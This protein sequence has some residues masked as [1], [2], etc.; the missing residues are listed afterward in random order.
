[1][2][3]APL[4]HRSRPLWWCGLAALLIAS[5][6]GVLVLGEPTDLPAL[7]AALNATATVLLIVGLRSIRGGKRELHRFVMLNAT[8]VSAAFLGSYL[9]YHLRVQSEVGPTPFRRE[10]AVKTAY[11]VMLASHVI[12]AMVNLPMVLR[13]L[14][15]AHRED[16]V[17]H[18]RLARW[19]WPIWFY[20]SLTGVL[21]YLAL[22][23]WN[24]PAPPDAP[25]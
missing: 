11:Y 25:R 15:L 23:H 18:R 8:L 3:Q 17:R 10:G 16:W 12:L 7:N 19:T 22:Y 21:V 1:M 2:T 13:T 4:E 24:L 9:Y 20:V 5:F 14:W 6:V